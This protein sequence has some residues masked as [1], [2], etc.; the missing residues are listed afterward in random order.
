MIEIPEHLRG[1][2][3]NHF[4]GRESSEEKTLLET[5]RSLHPEYDEEVTRLMQLWSDSGDALAQPEFDTSEA[6]RE[7]ES[8]LGKKRTGLWVR[9]P[10]AGR[11]AIAAT[12]IGALVMVGGRIFSDRTSGDTATGWRTVVAVG[13]NEKIT[14][15]DGSTVSLRN[16]ATLQYPYTFEGSERKVMLAGEA[17][18]D[19]RPEKNHPFRIGTVRSITEVLGTSFLVNASSLSDTIIVTTGRVL[20]ADKSQPDRNCILSEKQEAILSEKGLEKK[21]VT[22]SNYLS[23]E[24]GRL[25]F[26]QTPLDQVAADLSAHYGVFV[27]LADTLA[28]KAGMYPINSEFTSQSLEQALDEI[29][30]LTGLQYKKKA[31]T[32]IIYQPN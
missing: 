10:L 6:W 3:E 23:W 2:L 12:M 31:A 32:F 17:F 8:R 20:F 22:S 24:T 13:G 1:A 25:V 28:P 30:V 7:M 29:R 21:P 26:R 5:W 18:F 11:I 19:I 16:G 14:L 15:P 9:L 27:Q 4:L